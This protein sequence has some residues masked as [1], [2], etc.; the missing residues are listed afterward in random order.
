MA[1]STKESDIEKTRIILGLLQSVERDGAQTQRHLA[2]E[3]GIALGLVNAYLKRCVSKGLVKVRGVPTRRYAYF[4]TPQGFAEKSRL[5]IEYV[6]YSFSLFRQAKKDFISVFETARS[7]DFLD[8]ILIGVSDLAEIAAICALDSGVTI[9]GVMDDASTLTRFVG[10]PVFKSFEDIPHI[11]ALVLTDLGATRETIDA[12][13]R[14][15]GA[16]RVLVPDLLLG[17]IR[18][19]NE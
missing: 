10:V 2:S 18:G 5:T 7:R 11:D 3:L 9:A 4:L 16:E 17:R 12:A 15:F 14:R 6:S 13:I 1:T 8:V 19:H